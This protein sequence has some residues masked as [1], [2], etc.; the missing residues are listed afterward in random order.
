MALFVYVMYDGHV[1]RESL[2]EA[3]NFAAQTV[4]TVGYGNWETPAITPLVSMPNAEL[5]RLHMRGYS[6]AFMILG[7]TFY[8][9]F[10][11][12]IVAA[13]IPPN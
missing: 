4:T 8:A 12:V 13:L 3:G 1:S 5:R 6:I 10:T 2:I 7:A 11:G 9:A